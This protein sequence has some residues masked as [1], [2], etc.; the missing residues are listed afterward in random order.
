M[1]DYDK[2]APTPPPVAARTEEEAPKRRRTRGKT[3]SILVFMVAV[4]LLLAT[5][6]SQLW[7]VFDVLNQFTL[8]LA[9]ISVAFLLGYFMPFGRLLT[10]FLL[11]L[12]GM[13]VVGAYPQYYSNKPEVIGSVQANEKEVRLFSFNT[14][15][16]NERA[17]AVA[18]EIMRVDPDVA[19]LVEFG[20]EKKIALDRIR[21]RFPYVAGCVNEPFCHLA[22]VSK[23]P[24]VESEAKA[25]WNGPP[26]I[27]VALGGELSG[28]EVIGVHTIRTP[29]IRAQ[30]M[31]MTALAEYLFQFDKK[32]IVMGD[33]NATPFSRLLQIF[34]DRTRLRRLT[35]LPTWPGWLEL[36]QLAIDHIF[37]SPEI[38]VIERERIGKLAGSDH[39]PV[40]IKVAVPVR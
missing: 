9:I 26:L 21:D 19:V 36:P 33:F 6:L 10:A 23:Y 2:L 39:F 30:F 4:G 17:E 15:L 34:T 7:V 31:Q 29:H 25:S 11:T 40:M 35:W 12:A 5:R 37:V 32:L 3:R 8:H 24:I 13:A 1:D 14:S 22:I 20:E 28:V 38:R 18:D 16:S 27:R